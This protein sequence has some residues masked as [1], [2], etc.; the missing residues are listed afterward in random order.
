[1]TG[2]INKAA[3]YLYNKYYLQSIDNYHRYQTDSRG[4]LKAL[5]E[6]QIVRL[7]RILEHCY[8]NV[9]F[10]RDGL[11]NVSFRDGSTFGLESLQQM[12]EI[13][14]LT[15]EDIKSA[16]SSLLSSDHEARGSYRNTS[17][18]S[19]GSPITVFQDSHYARTAAGLFLFVKSMRGVDPFDYTVYLW[20]A[21]RDLY[22][23]KNTIIGSF[24]D[25]VNNIKKFNAARLDLASITLFIE[26]INKKKPAMVVAYAQSIYEVAKLVKK[27]KLKVSPQNVIHTGAGKLFPHMRDLIVEVFSCEV[28]DHYGGRE[29]GAVATECRDHSGLHIL[30]DEKFVEIVGPDNKGVVGGEGDV[31]VT[32]LNNWSMPLLRYKVG[33]QAIM[34]K[35]TKCEC[36]VTYPKLQ[37]IIGRT[38]NNFKLNDGGFVSGEYLTLT[39]NFVEGVDNFQIRQDSYDVITMFM[40]V[41]DAF[42]KLRVESEKREKFKSLFGAGI[43]VKFVYV[44]QIPLTPTGKHLFTVS[45]L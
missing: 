13:P 40:V 1:M 2:N 14:V 41:N 10:Y 18:G 23:E 21:H 36:G 8:I 43:E 34:M 17:G 44:D 33:D 20:G 11:H 25:F 37:S 32:T 19:T 16:G 45:M 6:R 3:V 22:G 7:N 30:A 38:A 39:F 5:E 15:K 31:L 29:F 42:E 4:T 9:P 28:F 24:K 35:S 27:H 12:E 26:H